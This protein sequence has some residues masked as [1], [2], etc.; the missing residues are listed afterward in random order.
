MEGGVRGVRG[1]RGGAGAVRG[2]RAFVLNS[3]QKCATIKK[4]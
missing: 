2:V 4:L 3:C 1:M